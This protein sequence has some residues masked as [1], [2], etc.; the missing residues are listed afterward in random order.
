MRLKKTRTSLRA[1]LEMLYMA[2]HAKYRT[3]GSGSAKQDKTGGT[4]S[5]K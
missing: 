2:S 1:T 3:R 5:V 4:S